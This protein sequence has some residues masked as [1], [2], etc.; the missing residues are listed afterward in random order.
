MKVCGR[1]WRTQLSQQGNL[2]LFSVFA[3]SELCPLWSVLSALSINVPTEAHSCQPFALLPLHL[4][5]PNGVSVG[6]SHCPQLPIHYL[7][8]TRAAP[9]WQPMSQRGLCR[10]GFV[11]CISILWNTFQ[12]WQELMFYSIIAFSPWELEV[13]YRDLNIWDLCDG[14]W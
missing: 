11:G 1:Q 9:A 3:S 5:P 2:F 10:K 12:N 14:W 6:L 8:H 7:N 4:N 13:K